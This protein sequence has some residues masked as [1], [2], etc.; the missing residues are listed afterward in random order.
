MRGRRSIA[1]SRSV[2]AASRVTERDIEL[3]QASA[4][5][6]RALAED[7]GRDV[8]SMVTVPEAAQGTARIELRSP[9]VIAGIAYADAVASEVGLTPPAWR[10][11]DGDT[12]TPGDLG[13]MIGPLRLLLSAE[14]PMLNLLQRAAGIATATR[15]FVDAVA[16]TGCRVL[17]TRKTAPGL[18]RLDLDAV[19]AGGGVAHR[20]G[21]AESVMVK[22][23][24][25]HALDQ[26]GRSL[27]EAFGDA[28]LLGVHQLM[29]EVESERQLDLACA[30]GAT[31]V[32]I[33][34]QSPDT[35]QRW[36]LRARAA[37]PGI[38]IEA[39]GGITLSNAR[40]YADAGADFISVGAL[41][42]SVRAADIALEI[43]D[44]GA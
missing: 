21:L 13:S 23:N 30:A 35:V 9:A 37:S 1:W 29:V 5:A 34:N 14:R 26:S 3:H 24:H 42:H 10:V 2:L 40:E 25:W 6:R 32:L 39:T 28:R 27:A 18:R 43:D 38:E 20:S 15:Q 44:H 36:G 12:A 7:G 22:D 11:R 17:H 16:G 33:D 4:I 19:R 8:T 31:R 41:T